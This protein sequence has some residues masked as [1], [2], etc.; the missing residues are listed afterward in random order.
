MYAVYPNTDGDLEILKLDPNTLEAVGSS[1]K[2]SK[3]KS[4]IKQSFYIQVIYRVHMNGY[5]SLIL[6]EL[7]SIE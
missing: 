4:E 3:P 5:S 2:T 1:F 7:G 6:F